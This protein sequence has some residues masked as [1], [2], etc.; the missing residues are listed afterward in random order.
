MG[1]KPGLLMESDLT[2]SAQDQLRPETGRLTPTG[3]VPC[4]KCLLEQL[5]AA[6]FD[7]T[8]LQCLL[9]AIKLPVRR[10][11]AHQVDE[12]GKQWGNL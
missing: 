1:L 3:F 5:L 11:F 4:G 12:P 6:L 8:R 7:R 10:I 2:V 9:E